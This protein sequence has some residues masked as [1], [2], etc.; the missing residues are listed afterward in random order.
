MLVG[1]LVKAV[2]AALLLLWWRV[3][4]ATPQPPVGIL[5]DQRDLALLVPW[6]GP[7]LSDQRGAFSSAARG[8][9]VPPPQVRPPG[10]G[11]ANSGAV[12]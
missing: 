11:S 2:S 12:H 7:D 4:R 6:W 8:Y 1:S 5:A 10:L 9:V 3:L